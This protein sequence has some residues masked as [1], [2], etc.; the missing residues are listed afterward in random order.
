[1]EIDPWALRETELNIGALAQT[2]SLFAL[3]NGHIG[4]R[5]NLDEGEPTGIAGTFLNGVYEIRPLPH[6]ETAYGY[7]EAGETVVSVPNG[8]LIRLL[9][10]DELMDA[11]YGERGLHRPGCADKLHQHDQPSGERGQ[12]P[13]TASHTVWAMI[14]SLRL[15]LDAKEEAGTVERSA[16]AG[17]DGGPGSLKVNAPDPRH[18]E[19]Q[20]GHSERLCGGI[21]CYCGNNGRPVAVVRHEQ[22]HAQIDRRVGAGVIEKL[23][24]E[25]ICTLGR[26]RRVAA[27]DAKHNRPCRSFLL[28]PSDITVDA[29]IV[30]ARDLTRVERRRC[31]IVVASGIGA[32][33]Q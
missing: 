10:D 14:I 27:V 16:G 18:E 4:M 22:A 21:E 7:P 6:A 26:R 12:G 23:H 17:V 28:Q 19:V 33:T 9:V 15:A 25:R 2:E 29:R 32:S 1:M 11:R 20:G 30:Q 3:S 24:D 8:K 5:G 31:R 13:R